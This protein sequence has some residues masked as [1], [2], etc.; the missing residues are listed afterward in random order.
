MKKI[1]NEWKRFLNEEVIGQTDN[2]SIVIYRVEAGD[3]ESTIM[4]KFRMSQQE[5][6]R[7]NPEPF[8]GEGST[9]KVKVESGATPPTPPKPPTNPLS[10]K[11]RGFLNDDPMNLN[12]RAV[13]VVY[14]KFEDEIEGKFTDVLSDANTQIRVEK[15]FKDN[16]VVIAAPASQYIEKM[17]A[18]KSERGVKQINDLL[19]KYVSLK[20]IRLL[21]KT[22]TVPASVISEQDED[23][24]IFIVPAL[25]TQDGQIK[26]FKPS[27]SGWQPIDLRATVDV[28]DVTNEPE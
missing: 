10:Y 22:K 9:V 25:I 16:N 18:A 20:V 21:M 14:G 2:P 12:E 5:Y 27:E 24:Q 11:D 19:R 15:Y 28:V 17:K 6:E 26:I 4:D 1:L 23:Q 13:G 3:T 8:K 7:L